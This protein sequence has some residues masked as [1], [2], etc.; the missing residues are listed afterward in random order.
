MHCSFGL[1]ELVSEVF[2][3]NNKFGIVFDLERLLVFRQPF[4]AL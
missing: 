4:L 2:T 3:K 1:N